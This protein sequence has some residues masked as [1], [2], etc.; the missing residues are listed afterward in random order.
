M[1]KVTFHQGLL[2]NLE[3]KVIPRTR[4]DYLPREKAYEMLK[5]DTGQ[6]FGY[7]VKAWKKWLE[8]NKKGARKKNP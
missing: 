7:D 1:S 8:E 5:K 2:L 3:G 4:R 6:D